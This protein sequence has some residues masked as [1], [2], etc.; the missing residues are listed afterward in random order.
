M[1]WEPG[2]LGQDQVAAGGQFDGAAEEGIGDEGQAGLGLRPQPDG[3]AAIG[4]RR[5]AAA[6]PP[7]PHWGRRA[8]PGPRPGRRTP[9]PRPRRGR[10]ARPGRDGRGWRRRR[11]WPPVASP[12][13]P[14]CSPPRPGACRRA[15]CGARVAAAGRS[16]SFRPEAWSSEGRRSPGPGSGRRRRARTASEATAI[17]VR[18][19]APY[20]ERD[21]RTAA[22]GRFR[23]A[24]RTG[25]A[26]SSSRPETVAASRRGARGARATLPS[27]WSRTQGRSRPSAW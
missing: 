22:C 2:G 16:L 23:P 15:A 7:G 12:R 9:C 13:S 3:A 14:P 10:G 17:R 18:M 25:V 8:G 24:G 26:G 20:A 1:R 5:S 27:T 11:R 4:S 19:E 6:G 21:Q